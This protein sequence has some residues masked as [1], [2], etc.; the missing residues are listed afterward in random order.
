MHVKQGNLGTTLRNLVKRQQN[1]G[2]S[3]K[4]PR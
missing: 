4:K 1:P 2:E 3:P